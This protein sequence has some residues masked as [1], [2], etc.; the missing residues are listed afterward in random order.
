VRENIRYGKLDATDDE[1]EMAA[2]V[3]GA[4]D[5][6]IHL[7]EGYDTF[8]TEGATNLSMGQ[9]QLIAF[10][11]VLVANPR[12]L[13]LDEATSSVDPYTELLIQRALWD[14]IENRTAFIIAHRL[15]T[16]R[17]ADR[18]IVVEQGEIVEEGSH[19]KL[20]ERNG[21]YSQL[22]QMQFKDVEKSNDQRD[23]Q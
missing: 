17:K 20:I 2:K 16:V 4:H 6:I 11:R 1:I 9:K 3:I 13:I 7:P 22:Y 5:F 14:L 12:I 10:A 8:V 21:L 15:S 23:A 18:I 19:R